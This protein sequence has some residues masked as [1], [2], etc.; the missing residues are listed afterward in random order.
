MKTNNGLIIAILINCRLI[1]NPPE[2][3]NKME[4]YAEETMT[5]FD[6]T[7]LHKK[8]STDGRMVRYRNEY[9]IKWE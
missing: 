1:E 8:W 4:L 7:R 3:D 9:A 2:V 6:I 5:I